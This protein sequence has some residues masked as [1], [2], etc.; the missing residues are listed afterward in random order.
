MWTL[1]DKG[2]WNINKPNSNGSRLNKSII[3][4][5]KNGNGRN[6]SPPSSAPWELSQSR[7]SD[8]LA[9]VARRQSR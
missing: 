4:P 7:Q 8:H 9:A 2:G 6:D 3:E 1:L 5:N